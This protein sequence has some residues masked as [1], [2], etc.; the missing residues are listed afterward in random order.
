[1]P[2]TNNHPCT[3]AADSALAVKHSLFPRAVAALPS[4]R[5]TLRQ[6]GPRHCDSNWPRLYKLINQTV[7]SLHWKVLGGLY[8][9]REKSK[10]V[11]FSFFHFITGIFA[12]W[13]I[14]TFKTV[15]GDLG[16]TVS[17]FIVNYNTILMLCLHINQS[18]V[19]LKAREEWSRQAGGVREHSIFLC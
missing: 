13:R 7:V 18:N 5:G 4:S 19:A 8:F 16:A 1:M 9:P 11:A 14:H 2:P 15:K 6:P 17:I 12:Q 3:L 10:R